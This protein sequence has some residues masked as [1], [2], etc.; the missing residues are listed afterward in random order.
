MVSEHGVE[1]VLLEVIPGPD[2]LLCSY[3]TYLDE[4]GEPQFHFTKRIIRRY[5]EHEGFACYHITDWNPEVRDLG[6]QLFRHAGLKGVANVEFKRDPRDGQLKLI[7]CNARFTAANGLLTASGI[8]LG[9]LRVQ[10]PGGP[11]AA[12]SRGRSLREGTSPVVPARRL[13]GVPRPQT[14]MG[15]WI[16]DPG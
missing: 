5:P 14:C 1:V 9:A 3:Y 12:P 11:A 16:W 7:E 15:G 2:D 6:L 10:P 13:P 8:D 4:A